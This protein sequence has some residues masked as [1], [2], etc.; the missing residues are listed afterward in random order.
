MNADQ[1][2]RNGQI[3]AINPHTQGTKIYKVSQKLQ[4][5]TRQGKGVAELAECKY[6]TKRVQGS[7][8]IDSNE[9]IYGKRTP[10]EP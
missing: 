9:L 5:Y 1:E 8:A 10:T 6:E 3:R 4:D 7:R 2:T